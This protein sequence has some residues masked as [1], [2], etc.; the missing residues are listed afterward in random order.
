METP[1]KPRARPAPGSRMLRTAVAGLG[2]FLGSM[3]CGEDDVT[4]PITRIS[5]VS[6]PDD[7]EVSGVV[8]LHVDAIGADEVRYE[9]EGD[10]LATREDPPFDYRW[11]TRNTPNGIHLL[12]AIAIGKANNARDEVE[13]IVNNVGAGA[14]TMILLE[15]RQAALELGDSLRFS[16]L[17]LG[18]TARGVDWIVLGGETDGTVDGT[19]LY[20]APVVLPRPPKATLVARSSVN[21]ALSVT[22]DISLRSP[23]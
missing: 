5:F 20:V 7:Q 22:A 17:V 19:G 4:A 14:E 10:F 13:I 16:A 9:I 11:N 8:E 3:G 1:L 21:A 2:I 12:Q 18:L 15:P 23:Q 6:I